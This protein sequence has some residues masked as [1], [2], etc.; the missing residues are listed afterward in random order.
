MK[1]RSAR[2]VGLLLLSLILFVGIGVWLH[3][4]SDAI[5]FQLITHGA[6]YHPDQ[7]NE[8]DPDGRYRLDPDDVSLPSGPDPSSA[9]RIAVWLADQ[10]PGARLVREQGLTSKDDDPQIRL[11]DF[12]VDYRGRTSP[13]VIL[14]ARRPGA[15]EFRGWVLIFDRAIVPGEIGSAMMILSHRPDLVRQLRHRIGSQWTLEYQDVSR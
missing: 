2:A 3:L 14:C 15:P 13:A 8:A 12:T 6:L 10:W 5:L 7:P 1:K 11:V 9:S 4:T